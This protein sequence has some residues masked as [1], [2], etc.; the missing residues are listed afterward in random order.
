MHPQPNELLLWTLMAHDRNLSVIYISPR[1]VRVRFSL[2][3]LNSPYRLYPS[4]AI[5]ILPAPTELPG[6]FL[7]IFQVCCFF[8]TLVF[9]IMFVLLFFRIY[10]TDFWR[11]RKQKVFN[12]TK[13]I[14]RFYLFSTFYC[15]GKINNKG[16]E[17]NGCGMKWKI[18][19][20]W[21]ALG[22]NVVLIDQQ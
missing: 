16:G 14:S 21:T 15:R 7:F 19:K 5:I 2:V 9:F 22:C 6:S 18:N 10:F 1:I 3:F 4:P 17:R 11:E 12:Y 8:L 13:S 20:W